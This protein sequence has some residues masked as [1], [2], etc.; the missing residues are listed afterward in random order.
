MPL[1]PDPEPRAKRYRI[2]SVDDHLCE[3]ADI[4]EGRLPARLQAAAPRVEQLEDGTEVWVMED[5]Q[6]PNVGLNA[7]VGR[8]KEEWNFEP[9]RF[10]EMRKGAWDI[11]ARVADMDI[12]GIDAS[13]CF[14]SLIAGFSGTRFSRMRDRELGLACVRA[15][16]DWMLDVWCGT[17]PGRQ[18]AQQI[19]WL[20]DP[21]VAADMI[22]ENATRGFKAV[23]MPEGPAGFPS[24]HTDYWD[25][26]LA[27]CEETETV[28]SLHTGTG[29]WS[30]T[31]SAEAPIEE[32]TALFPACGLAAAADWLWAKVPLRFPNIKIAMSEGGIGWVPMLLDRMDYMVNHELGA[33]GSHW[34]GDI[35]PNEA[36]QRNFWFCTIDDPS[37]LPLLE[38]IG[39]DLVMLEVDY[40]H[41][42][43]TWPDTQ[44]FIERRMEDVLTSEQIEKVT[45]KN[46]SHLFRHPLP[47]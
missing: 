44:D 43:S 24:V 28:I 25:P 3:P 45:W 12:G 16:N 31:M 15:W 7:V 46:A 10:D 27:A 20:A 14:P 29:E 1:L 26:I 33:V 40:P 36:L 4:F 32:R 13:L 5:E 23:T 6:L 35:T 47:G 17:Y 18:I 11:D 41:A 30:S 22:R 38:R 34:D 39:E 19:T 42:S 21:Q 8:P 9:T 37:T 2:I